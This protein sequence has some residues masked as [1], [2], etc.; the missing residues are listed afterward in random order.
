M[1]IDAK[2]RAVIEADLAAP[3]GPR[4]VISVPLACAHKPL[5]IWIWLRWS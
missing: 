4:K 3:K 1:G 5:E 2:W